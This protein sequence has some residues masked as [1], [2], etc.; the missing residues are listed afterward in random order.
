MLQARDVRVVLGG[1]QVLRRVS[2]AVA[3]G[4]VVA[5]AGPNGAGKS[6]LLHVLSG[7]LPP[8]AG[9]VCLE[10]YPLAT[11]T[12]RALARRR[13]V[14]PQHQELS[15][16][17]R[18]LDV[19]LL[20]RLPHVGTSSSGMDLEIARAC[21]VE[22][23][24]EHLAERIYTTLS[25]GERQRVQLARVLAQ[26]HFME[27]GHGL[28]GR[29]LLLD[30]P[31]SCGDP[32]RRCVSLEVTRRAARRGVGAVVVL[33]DLDLAA[34]YGDRVVV[35]AGGRVLAEGAPE[36][37]V[38]DPTVRLAFDLSARVAPWPTHGAAGNARTVQ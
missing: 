26:I 13:A 29:Y 7:S 3:P 21:L 33:H 28:A 25:G 37:V 38:T 5:V 23:S 2:L 9:S 24:A 30:E 31:A 34:M 32:V 36:E 27:A 1:A 11:W 18:A 16:A 14:L 12:P 35:L 4:Q 8:H 10:N 19:V 17:F 15:F 20:G 22:T 6:T